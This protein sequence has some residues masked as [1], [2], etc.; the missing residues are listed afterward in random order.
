MK[1]DGQA[2]TTIWVDPNDRTVVKV[3]DQRLLPHEFKVSDLK[4]CGDAEAAIK[5]MVVRGAPLIGVTA[6]YGIYLALVGAKGNENFDEVIEEAVQ[7][8]GQARPTAVNL[9]WAIQSQLDAISQKS[10]VEEKIQ[11][12]FE[13]AELIRLRDIET[14]EKIGQFGVKLIEEI[15]Q[16][17]NG[18]VVNILTHC[19]AGWF[20]TIDWGT[21]TSP[22]Y[23]AHLKGIKVHV[24]VDETRPRNQGANLTAY[25]L[26][27][28]GVPH[29]LIV[30][31]TGGHLMQQ[32]MVD[33]VITGTDRTT[34]TGDAAN[35]IG[36][37]LKALAAK[38]NDVP[39]YI[40]LPSTTIDWEIR[41][42]VKDIPIEQRDDDEVK[43]IVG[44]HDGEVKRVLIA[45]EDSPAA[46]YAFD[47]TPSRLIT[48][49]IT[50][51][52]ICDASEEGIISLFPEHA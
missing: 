41:D 16:R 8:L 47:V 40:A 30:D 33:I 31:N 49:L 52:G 14:S 21:A 23:K 37:Y 46:N 27:Q 6:A 3:I 44:K 51:R 18:E 29:T 39:F 7:S 10:S 35:K 42:G 9:S 20:A 38:D 1:I 11:A 5:D 2:Y 13:N 19:N 17:K 36:T 43:Y 28:E 50:E 45:P 4:T 15:S 26:G 32:G 24:W 48:G 12:A 22:I 34:Y 25:E